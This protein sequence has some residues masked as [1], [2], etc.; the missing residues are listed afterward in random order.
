MNR[1]NRLR[2]AAAVLLIHVAVSLFVL[3]LGRAL[4]PDP[5]PTLHTG[6]HQPDRSGVTRALPETDGYIGSAETK[7]FHFFYC[8]YLPDAENQV[9][10]DSRE[11]AIAAGYSPCGHCHP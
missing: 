3:L 10:F 11:D 9:S 5:T 2:L 8:S 7:K 6:G 1:S 4:S